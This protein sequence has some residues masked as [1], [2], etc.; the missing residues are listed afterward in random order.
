MLN[1]YV[2]LDIGVVLKYNNMKISL[3]KICSLVIFTF[4]L[5]AGDTYHV[6]ARDREQKYK[7][8]FR[9]EFNLPDG[10]QPNPKLWSRVPRANNLWAK[11]NSDTADVVFIKNGRLVCRVIPNTNPA[12]T[13]MMLAGAVF[14]KHKFAFKYGKIE[15]RMRTNLLKGNFPAAW[16]MPQVPGNPYRYGEVDLIEYFGNEG[17]ARQTI[18]SHRT[19]ILKKS[20][21][22]TVFMTRNIS[23]DKWHVYGLEWT[24]HALVTSIDGETT[25]CYLKS[26]DPVK[27]EEGQWSFDRSFFIIL[28]QSV[29]YGNWHAPD[30]HATY[31]TEFDWVRIYQR[32]KDITYY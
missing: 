28:N 18:H 1:L 19:A 10:S 11:W 12:D 17:I 21:Q 20:D 9:E 8:V 4:C 14:T 6:M 25:G 23:R 3:N 13:A 16:I 27:L 31:E 29:G 2:K 26:D 15:V 7:L 32:E 22:K 24:P 5:L 30:P